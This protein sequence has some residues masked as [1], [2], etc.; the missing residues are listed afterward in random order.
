M[1]IIS[2]SQVAEISL[3]EYS[4]YNS[5]NVGNDK[6]QRLNVLYACLMAVKAFFDYHLATT[7]AVYVS[8]S[9]SHWIYSSYALLIAIK[10][11]ACKAE[12]WDFQHAR[13][14]LRFSEVTDILLT[15]MEAALAPFEPRRKVH[16]EN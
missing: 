2:C 12:G 5:L 16:C 3:H 6:A 10:L 15:K 11:C 8:Q 1:Q 4:L 9:Y 14:L 13:D 7:S